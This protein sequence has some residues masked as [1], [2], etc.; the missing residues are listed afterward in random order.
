[1]KEV[2]RHSLYKHFKG[3]LYYVIGEAWHSENMDEMVVYHALYGDNEMWVR[4]KAEFLS[5]VEEGKFNPSG[6]KYRFEPV[7]G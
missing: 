5:E 6:Q 3:K 1:M 2:L 7:E 4:P